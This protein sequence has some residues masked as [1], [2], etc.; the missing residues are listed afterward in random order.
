MPLQYVTVPHRDIAAGIDSRSRLNR[1]ADGYSEELVNV[2]TSLEG[3]LAKRKGYQGYAGW[4]PVWI[5]TLVTS[6]PNYLITVDD[7]YDLSG[8]PDSG[9]PTG[10]VTT[11]PIRIVSPFE[12]PTLNSVQAYHT[13]WTVTGP[14]TL[15][16]SGGGSLNLTG[17]QIWGLGHAGRYI[18]G[19]AP[20]HVNFLGTY[21]RE[22]EETLVAGQGG[23]LFTVA[24]PSALSTTITIEAVPSSN[25]VLGPRFV[26]TGFP[27]STRTNGYV[28]ANNIQGGAAVITAATWLGGSSVQYTLDMPGKVVTG[29]LSG[30]FSTTAGREDFLSVTDM[31]SDLLNGR[32]RIISISEPDAVT[33]Q[34]VVENDAIDTFVWDET[35]AEGSASVLTD[36]VPVGSSANFGPGDRAFNSVFD[37]DTD[38]V[39][40]SLAPAGFLSL[41][42][43]RKEYAILTTNHITGRH[44]GDTFTLAALSQPVLGDMVSQASADPARYPSYLRQFRVTA[45]TV[46]DATHCSKITLDES[47]AMSHGD[48]V[49]IPARWS[50][51][52][53]PRSTANISLYIPS[54]TVTERPRIFDTNGYADQSRLRATVI[55]DSM[56]FSNGVD[57]TFKFDG[58]QVYRAGMPPWPS[59]VAA[60]ASAST[61]GVTSTTSASTTGAIVGTD[62]T[63]VSD[64]IA[65]LVHE[66]GFVEDSA[67]LFD[68]SFVYAI[69]KVDTVRL[70]A[71]IGSEFSA[72][73][74]M[75][76]ISRYKY[77]T[78]INIIDTNG[79]VTAS[80]MSQA[81]D[82][83]QFAGGIVNG[84]FGITLADVTACDI[85]D[86]DRIEIQLYRTAAG[87][88]GLAAAAPYYLVGSYLTTFKTND[89]Y[90]MI[91]DTLGDSVIV[92]DGNLDQLS[93]LK[94]GELGTAWDQ[95]PRAR[96]ITSA[97]SR[98]VQAYT[99]GYPALDVTLKRDSSQSDFTLRHKF[100]LSRDGS[101][102]TSNMV[103]RQRI[104]PVDIVSYT[105][106][107]LTNKWVV[108]T[109]TPNPFNTMSVGA[110]V[111]LETKDRVQFTT[112]GTLPS[113]LTAGTDYFVVMISQLTGTFSLTDSSGTPVIFTT[114]GT[115]VLSVESQDRVQIHDTGALVGAGDYQ[116][117]V[118]QTGSQWATLKSTKQLFSGGHGGNVLLLLIDTV[119][120]AGYATTR[121]SNVDIS[122]SASA[123]TLYVALDSRDIPLLPFDTG[124]S[125]FSIQF[126]IENSW[127]SQFTAALNSAMMLWSRYYSGFR[128]WFTGYSGNDFGLSRVVLKQTDVQDPGAAITFESVPFIPPP[129]YSIYVNGLLQNQDVEIPA[130]APVFPSRVI[131]SYPNY[132]EIMD[133]PDATAASDSDSAIDVNASDGQEIT[134]IIPFFGLTSFSA[135]QMESNVVVFK[136]ASIY[137]LNVTTRQLNK[138]DS[139]GI[140]CTA[141]DSIAGTQDGIMFAND[142]GIYKLNRDLTVSFV[143]GK[144]LEGKWPRVNK[145]ALGSCFAYQDALKRLYKLSVPFDAEETN[146]NMFVYDHTRERG[147][148]STV[149]SSTGSWVQYNNF[150]ATY[151]TVTSNGDSFFGTTDGQVFI[152]RNTGEIQDYRDDDQAVAEMQVRYKACDFGESGT[153]KAVAAVVTHFDFAEGA[154]M[155]GTII[156]TATDLTQNFE[157]AATVAIQFNPNDL[158]DRNI[159]RI[160]SLRATPARRRGLFMQ[161]QYRNSVKDE[162]VIIAG[163]DFI[164][165]GLTIRKGITEAGSTSGS[166]Q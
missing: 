81:Q 98:L 15:T 12:L 152:M 79:N 111:Y 99:K 114:A 139:R 92:N 68:Y 43:I 21:R 39:T 9:G 164:V 127:A 120:A 73:T 76:V 141:P 1:L 133:A 97:A 157:E 29:S 130:A 17:G 115:G 26:P 62:L 118:G 37:L 134:G 128:P 6:G 46:A 136:T 138:L 20:G 57:E 146:N 161:V 41:D 159:K 35:G 53:I 49:S 18:S 126:K 71:I 10:V 16:I 45:V 105:T 108:A 88:F 101:A 66:G 44:S 55:N 22:E 93:S 47:V 82:F 163:I 165:A 140:G 30:I 123:T 129:E 84:Y 72:A 64:N 11:R 51:I 52:P 70:N 150:P 75:Q 103:D 83:D 104:D 100:L 13:S 95:P 94:S 58:D 32:F 74:N 142:S 155:A 89:N 131:V 96:Y 124:F 36:L 77:Y 90:L 40:V 7:S 27:A 42:G 65:T 109:I 156:E 147:A 122:L 113:G 119:P 23:N 148:S 121:L 162:P 116:L 102:G 78:R 61:G 28:R 54:T 14:H 67:H 56:F 132:P 48:A 144:W 135:A 59:I 24:D 117:H 149:P 86:W 110:P 33:I 38:L 80:A 91:A 137:L 63:L 19:S 145:A 25:I 3:H 60:C 4:L 158:Y 87:D 8:F 151:W 153:R 34:I 125:S 85:Y 50:P 69:P 2:D 31:N 143:E 106:S 107:T 166:Q 5:K 154:D 112:T 160:Q